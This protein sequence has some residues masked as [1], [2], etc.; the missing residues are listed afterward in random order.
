MIFRKLLQLRPCLV[1]AVF[2]M[3]LMTGDAFAHQQCGSDEHS[4][5][6]GCSFYAHNHIEP[7]TPRIESDTP[8]SCGEGDVGDTFATAHDLG[9]SNDW[10]RH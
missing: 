4:V 3:L 7:D 6:D 8:G 9:N 5:S 10:P 2:A 1:G